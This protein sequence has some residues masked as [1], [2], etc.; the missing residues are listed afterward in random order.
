MIVANPQEFSFEARFVAAAGLFYA[1]KVYRGDEAFPWRD[2]GVSEAE[3]WDLWVLG[4]IDIAQPKPAPEPPRVVAK[5]AAPPPTKGAKPQQPNPL[6]QA[7][8][9]RR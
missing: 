5:P 9:P 3:L 8:P 1:G 7:A 2:I 4:C 6:L